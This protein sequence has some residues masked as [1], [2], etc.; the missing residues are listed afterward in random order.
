MYVSSSKVPLIFVIIKRDEHSSQRSRTFSTKGF[1]NERFVLTCRLS[2]KL[3][4]RHDANYFTAI[5]FGGLINRNPLRVA[6]CE[7]ARGSWYYVAL[8]WPT[9]FS[10]TM[11][12]NMCFLSRFYTT[13][14]LES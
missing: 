9:R 3:I 10:Y 7:S 4:R 5:I 1:H 2:K 8:A 12:Y 13:L 14:R 11:L 6:L